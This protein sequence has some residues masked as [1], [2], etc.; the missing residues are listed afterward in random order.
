M[1]YYNAASELK[2]LEWYEDIHDMTS[3]AV[4]QARRA[5]LEAQLVSPRPSIKLQVRSATIKKGSHRYGPRPAR[6]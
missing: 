4:I 6:S 5:W 2:K 3:E 1:E